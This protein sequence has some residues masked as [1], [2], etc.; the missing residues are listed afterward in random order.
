[1]NCHRLA[2]A[3]SSIRHPSTHFTAYT[4]CLSC[5]MQQCA[6]ELHIMAT[7]TLCTGY[8]KRFA[9]PHVTYMH[10]KR[11][12]CTLHPSTG[13][14]PSA[15]RAPV[16]RRL[17]IVLRNSSTPT[18]CRA[19]GPGEILCKVRVAGARVCARYS[20][21]VSYNCP[22]CRPSCLPVVKAIPFSRHAKP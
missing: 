16:R 12:T 19:C 14:P 2:L 1:M 21:L 18:N 5:S 13:V 3:V 4:S 8:L 22:W 11:A 10:A 9:S 15:P 17:A 6:G 7:A 20:I